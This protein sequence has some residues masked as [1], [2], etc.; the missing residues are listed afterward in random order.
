[1]EQAS[2]PEGAALP[3]E[4]LDLALII[5]LVSMIIDLLTKLGIIG[6]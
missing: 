2:R 6:G 4:A 5:Q 1:M 3:E